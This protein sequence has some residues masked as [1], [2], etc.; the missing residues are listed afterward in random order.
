MKNISKKIIFDLSNL[1]QWL[2]ANKIALNFNKND[3]VIFHFPRKQV[4]QK[5]RQKTCTKYLGILL[6][7]H[8]LFKKHINT[9]KQ[10]L[11]GAMVFCLN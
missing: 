4:L 6:D 11:N 8:L 1:V 10:K 3:I 5:I 2:Q 7:G 9:L